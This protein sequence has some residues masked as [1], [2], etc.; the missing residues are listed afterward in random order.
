MATATERTYHPA[1]CIFPLLDDE[2]L[3]SLVDDI[4]E[5]GLQVPI[6]V[7]RS[8][9][10]IDGRNRQTACLLAG[11]EPRYETCDLDDDAEIAQLV[12]S[13]NETRRHLTTGQR[14]AAATKLDELLEKFR[15]EAEERQKAGKGADGSGGRGKKK[16]LGSADP[17]VSGDAEAN[18]TASKL[19]AAT[20][21]SSASIKRTAAVKKNA[22]DLFEKIE[23]GELAVNAA[24]RKMKERQATSEGDDDGGLPEPSGA[25]MLREVR[26]ANKY[27]DKC[28][29]NVAENMRIAF[30]THVSNSVKLRIKG[31]E[32][33]RRQG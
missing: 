27:I 8:G 18:K 19:A 13:L 3:A 12:W 17:K 23:S 22:P 31:E 2:Q 6:L 29:E 33:A 20:G 4:R 15:L 11:V 26:R 1:A 21:V 14:A 32:N 10:I 16:T 30:L 7:D 28:L 24:Y 9:R 5:R 25:A